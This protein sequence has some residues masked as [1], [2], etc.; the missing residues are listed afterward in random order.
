[1]DGGPAGGEPLPGGLYTSEAAGGRIDIFE[2]SSHQKLVRV[3]AHELGHALGLD[4]VADLKAIMYDSNLGTKAV[5]TPADISAL[6][7]LCTAK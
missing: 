4:H 2:F 1:M 7:Q 3:L 5:L 6:N